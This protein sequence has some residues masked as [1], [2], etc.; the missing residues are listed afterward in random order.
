MGSNTA[1]SMFNPS[2]LQSTY[3]PLA[4]LS[5]K[6]LPVYIDKSTGQFKKGGILDKIGSKA[7]ASPKYN[8]DAA[9]AEQY[10]INQ[11][12]ANQLYA[13]VNSPL[14]GYST[15]VDPE[16]GQITVNKQLSENSQTALN[17]QQAALK[18]YYVNDGT[19]AANA[20]YNAQMAYLQPQMQRQITRSEA[21]LTNRGLPIGSSAWNEYMGDV[22]D[23]QNQQLS[24]LGSSAIS[25]GQGYQSNFLD[26]ANMLGGQVLDPSIVSGQA[27][28]GLEN[29]YDQQFGAQVA[30]YKTDMAG[31]NIHQ[32]IGGAVG[33]IGGAVLG[34]YLTEGNPAGIYGGA[35]IGGAGGT[36]LGT[37]MDNR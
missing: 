27:G 29:T 4:G 15:Y 14:G 16:T 28:A 19:D 24:S 32:Q 22:R 31:S 30:Q 35:A 33:T 12:T 21:G 17:Q 1:K 2:A 13:D 3:N 5:D 37:A 7:P 23:A 18:N 34:G 11:T 26:Q 10:R 8:Q 25:A 6:T 20:Y 9:R 36:A